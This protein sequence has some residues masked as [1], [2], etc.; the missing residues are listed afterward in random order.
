MSTLATLFGAQPCVLCTLRWSLCAVQDAKHPLLV[1]GA[2]ANR[3]V[4]SNML[5]RLVENTGL[6]FCDTQMGKGVVDSSARWAKHARLG[7]TGP[8]WRGAW[9]IC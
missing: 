6:P 3:K 1:N 7:A 9:H 8:R 5:R 4:T 2:G